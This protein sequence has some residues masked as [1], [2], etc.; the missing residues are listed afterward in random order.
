MYATAVIPYCRAQLGTC[1]SVAA[2][3]VAV[4]W[5][6]A[7]ADDRWTGLTWHWVAVP[8]KPVVADDRWTGLTWH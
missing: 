6:P 1:A 7:V 2:C 4:P 8:W 3:P 5:K